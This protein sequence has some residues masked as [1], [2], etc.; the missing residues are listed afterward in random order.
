MTVITWLFI[1]IDG[2]ERDRLSALVA[3][4][5][6]SRLCFYATESATSRLPLVDTTKTGPYKVHTY[7]PVAPIILPSGVP[8]TEIKAWWCKVYAAA[9]TGLL[10]GV[11]DKYDTSVDDLS[12]PCFISQVPP[13][14]DRR[15]AAAVTDANFLD[16]EAYVTSL[17]HS[18][19]RPL[20]PTVLPPTTPA[21]SP[22]RH[23]A[24]S[25][26]RRQHG[27]QPTSRCRFGRPDPRRDD[28]IACAYGNQW[29]WPTRS[30][31]RHQAPHV[32]L[33]L[34]LAHRSP[35]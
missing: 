8:A 28:R 5:R 34:P 1:D 9:V 11:V 33:S 14:G 35:D 13:S 19:P 7:V 21:A 18:I 3:K 2:I 31:P 27:T 29:T 24:T 22:P 17:G 16:L 30:H 23:L 25:P 20:P 32:V 15:L 12:Q 4:L 10:A 6:A 26:Q